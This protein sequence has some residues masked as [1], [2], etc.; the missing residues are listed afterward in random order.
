LAAARTEGDERALAVHRAAVSARRSVIATGERF[1]FL[2]T[3]LIPVLTLATI[4][5]GPITAT[6]IS[7]DGGAG[8][9]WR[10]HF[11]GSPEIEAYLDGEVSGTAPVAR[12]IVNMVPR[13]IAASPGLHLIGELPPITGW[14][15]SMPGKAKGAR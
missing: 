14:R 10:L 2:E 4:D 8:E 13:V 1:G 5:R 6:R 15:P 12:L 11:E 9:S 3:V 7:H